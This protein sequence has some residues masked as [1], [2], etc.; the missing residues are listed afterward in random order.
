MK[1]KKNDFAKM[2]QFIFDLSLIFNFKKHFDNLT[3]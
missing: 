3:I 2:A 1:E